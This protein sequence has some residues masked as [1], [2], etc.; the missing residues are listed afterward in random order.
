MSGHQLTI[1]PGLRA[2]ADIESDCFTRGNVV[3]LRFFCVKTRGNVVITRGF[4]VILR[5]NCDI[6]AVRF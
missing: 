3:S 1:R 5:G 4:C 6:K 2:G